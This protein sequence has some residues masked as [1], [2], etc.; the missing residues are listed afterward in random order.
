M[1]L[2]SK[3]LSIVVNPFAAPLGVDGAA[4]ALCAVDPRE[5]MGSAYIGARTV[6]KADPVRRSILAIGGKPLGRDKVSVS[7]ALGPVKVPDTSYYRQA[8]KA[9]DVFAAEDAQIK[10]LGAA[11]RRLADHILEGGDREKALARWRAQGLGA[12]ADAIPPPK[13]AHAVTPPDGIP[14]TLATE[15]ASS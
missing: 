7:Y 10:L 15:G 11:V 4:M 8:I 12:I 2:S 13:F 9:G 6:A 5:P 3:Q 14:V 1:R